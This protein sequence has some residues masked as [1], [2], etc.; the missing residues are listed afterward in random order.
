MC[1]PR[2]VA[3]TSPGAPTSTPRCNWSSP[4]A[5][6][7]CRTSATFASSTGPPSIQSTSS[8]SASLAKKSPPPDNA[9]A[10]RK[11]REVGCGSTPSEAFAHYDHN[12]SSWRTSPPCGGGTADSTAFSATWPR[13]GTTRSGAAFAPPTSA[14]HT[15]ENACSCSPG[16]LLPTPQARDG[17][18]RGPADPTR[19]RALGRQVSLHDVVSATFAAGRPTTHG[20]KRRS[21]Q[22][23]ARPTRASSR[24]GERTRGGAITPQP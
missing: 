13:Q 24:R 3:D 15:V 22:S 16:P 23:P 21:T 19:R 4:R 6:P 7:A 14:H 8:P 17:D 18:N 12:S 2:S 11:E 10:S 1:S 9:R 5:C 20:R